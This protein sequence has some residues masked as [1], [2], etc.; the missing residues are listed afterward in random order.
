MGIIQIYLDMFGMM[1]TPQIYQTHLNKLILSVASIVCAVIVLAL[2]IATAVLSKKQRVIGVIAGLFSFISALTIPLFVR[3]WHELGALIDAL[4]NSES[5]TSIEAA[6]AILA[7][8][9]AIL[10]IVLIATA[11]MVIATALTIVY[12]AKSF[13]NKPAIFSVAALVLVIL[14]QLWVAP[15]PMMVPMFAK[16]FLRM[17]ESSPFFFYDQVF[18]ICAYF[19]VLIIALVLV[20][21]PVIIKK[22]KGEAEA[23]E[24][25]KDEAKA[26]DAKADEAAE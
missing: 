6:Y 9:L 2:F 16:L 24:A 11:V 15:F 3:K 13:K 7:E 18:Q 14:R 26:E 19:G 5:I 23:V 8:S 22:V 1:M 17:P 4:N 25:P 21:V 10:V 20:L 12:V